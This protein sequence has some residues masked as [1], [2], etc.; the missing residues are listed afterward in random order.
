MKLGIFS[1]CTIDEIKIGNNMYE[2]PGGP[3][4]Y[5]GIAAR[6]MGF[7]VE[8]YTKFGPDYIYADDLKKHKIKFENALSEKNTTRFQLQIDDTDRTL[9]IKNSCDKIDYIKT[10]CDGLLISPVFDEVSA[11]VLSKLKSDARLVALDPQGFLRRAGPDGKISFERTDIDL[12]KISILKSDPNEVYQ[13]CGVHGMDGAKIL[14]KKVEHLLYTNKREVSLFYKNK[15][16]SITLPNMDIYDTVGVG[17]IF[18]ST[19]CCTMLKEKDAL[20]ALSFAGGA[21]QAALE[22]KEVGLDKVPPKGATQT[23]ASYYY[24]IIKF[25]DV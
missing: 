10:N 19:Y 21:A 12:G 24:N 13:L 20:W 25:E 17:D 14:H 6:N 11:N 4:C 16:Y 2:K 3:A 15:R 7:D 23:N 18:T 1:H 5:C 22:S 9:W 8:L